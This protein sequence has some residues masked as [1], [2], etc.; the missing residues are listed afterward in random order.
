MSFIFR[1]PAA[2]CRITF[3]QGFVHLPENL[4]HA[5]YISKLLPD[6]HFYLMGRVDGCIVDGRTADELPTSP[7]A[8]AHRVNHPP[9][10]RSANVLQ[11]AYDYPSQEGSDPR[12]GGALLGG[13]TGTRPHT[14]PNRLRSLIPNRCARSC[15]G[16]SRSRAFY[17]TKALSELSRDTF[18]G[19]R[20]AWN[21]L[22]LTD[23]A[24]GRAVDRFLAHA[25]LFNSEAVWVSPLHRLTHRVESTFAFSSASLL[26]LLK[27]A[28]CSPVSNC[29]LPYG[30]LVKLK[31]NQPV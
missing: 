6:D 10:G 7:L 8:V 28:Q 24:Q 18:A 22:I 29:A 23:P 30:R 5:D 14:F 26:S 4:Q 9:A 2:R 21:S 1:C 31:A 17:R 19:V 12:L 3:W 13:V 11:A 16:G 27:Y 20:S 25:V 15:N